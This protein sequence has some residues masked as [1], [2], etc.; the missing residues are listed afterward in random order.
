M[1]VVGDRSNISRRRL[2]LPARCRVE[3]EADGGRVAVAVER[4]RMTGAVSRGGRETPY[5]WNAIFPFLLFGVKVVFSFLFPSRRE[6]EWVDE[7]DK[8]GTV[9]PRGACFCV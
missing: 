6:E 7:A 8:P 2:V 1:V 4:V 9:G 3:A 5:L